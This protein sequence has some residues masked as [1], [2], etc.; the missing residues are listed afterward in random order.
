VI[1]REIVEIALCGNGVPGAI[2]CAIEWKDFCTHVIRSHIAI[3]SPP[4]R[5]REIREAVMPGS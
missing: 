1:H 2:E 5:A 3:A 4:A